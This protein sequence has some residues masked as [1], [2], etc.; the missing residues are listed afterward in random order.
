MYIHMAIARF[1]LNS[2]NAYTVSFTGLLRHPRE[3]RGDHGSGVSCYCY[4]LEHTGE[5]KDNAGLL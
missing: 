4:F 1:V 3:R 2:L 5:Y